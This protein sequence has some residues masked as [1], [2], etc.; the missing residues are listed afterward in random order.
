M[1]TIPRLAA[2]F[3]FPVALAMVFAGFIAG[4]S[5]SGGGAAALPANVVTLS[6][7]WQLQDVAKVPDRAR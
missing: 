7:G 2:S 6:S 1:K 5:T 4:C 3:I